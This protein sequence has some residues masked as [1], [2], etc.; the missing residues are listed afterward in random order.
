MVWG[1]PKGHEVLQCKVRTKNREPALNLSLN[2]YVHEPLIDARNDHDRAARALQCDHGH[3]LRLPCC[4]YVHEGARE[5]VR[6]HGSGYARGYVSSRHG[7][8]RESGYGNDHARA[9]AC[10]RAFLPFCLSLELVVC[11]L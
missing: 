1:V 11:Y 7:S 4:G 3:E 10:V 6:G 9:D 5:D 8:V 2:G